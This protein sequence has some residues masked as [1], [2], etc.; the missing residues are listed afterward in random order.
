M[1]GNLISRETF[2]EMETD[3]K[4]NVLFDLQHGTMKAVRVLEA[5]KI[6]N[7][8]MAFAGGLVGG[9]VA[10]VGKGAITGGPK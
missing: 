10:M 5:R 3:D 6:F 2:V 7:S 9:A 1:N 4:L 8:A